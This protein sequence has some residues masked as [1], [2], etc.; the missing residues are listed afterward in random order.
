[1]TF[2]L[3][4]LQVFGVYSHDPASHSAFDESA[5]SFGGVRQVAGVFGSILGHR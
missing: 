3:V 4:L 5:I 1:M 2:L